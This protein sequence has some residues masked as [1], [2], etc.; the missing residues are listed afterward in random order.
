[1]EVQILSLALN[2]KPKA[3]KVSGFPRHFFYRPAWGITM[4]KRFAF[5]ALAVLVSTAV[6]LADEPTP[7][8]PP[9]IV[10]VLADDLGWRD[11]GCYGSTFYETPNLDQ[12]AAEGMR[13]TDAYAT[14]CVCSPTRASIMSGKYPAR[15]HLTDF[16]GGTRRGK[17]N[18]A[19]Y[20][21]HLPIEEFTLADALKAGGYHTG[22]IGKWHLGRKPY[23]P[24]KRGFDSNVAGCEMGAPHT[25]FSPYHIPT[26]TDG[27]T[28]EYLTDR[29][30]DEAIKFL[31]ANKEKPFYLYLCHYAVHIPLQAKPLEQAKYRAKAAQLPPASGPE[32]L[33][34]GNTNTRQI[35]NRPVYAAMVES[36][37]QSVGR[38]MQ[39]LRR[40]GLEDN[41]IVVFNS[42]NGGL[43]SSSEHA[44][45]SNAPLRAGKGWNYE[46]G[47]R[48]PLI[49][50]WPG[51]VQAGS[52]CHT[53][54]ISTD[55][56]PTLLD[57]VGLPQ[58]P[59]QTVDGVSIIPLLKGKSLAER[60]LFW[61][62]PHYS[63]QGGGPCG[64]IR[65]G[66]YKLVEWYEDMHV[67][68]FN[69]KDD[70]GEHHD[71]S[72]SLPD[73]VAMIRND[74]HRWRKSVD[75]TMPTPNP[76]YTSE[77]VGRLG[78]LN[79]GRLPLSYVAVMRPEEDDD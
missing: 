13:F 35:Q 68:L 2:D 29:L 58:R 66:D 18:P 49:V 51:V 11:L 48:E 3:E 10:F 9:N 25:Y 24:E 75:A 19:P 64:A 1:V 77:K 43:S 57:A 21:D 46:G 50:R 38:I 39:E 14:C 55:Y 63:N 61:H 79:N 16:I 62:Y 41:T 34:E 42:D 27:P 26:L 17:L 30:T 7:R 73:K 65:L 32:F 76:D 8:R 74:L 60:A 70:I 23:W 31:N 40:L 71:L 37:D 45:T 72:R 56:Y 4:Q 12:L 22:F 6:A 5:A 54:V 33:P 53:P 28:G 69:L 67:E 52:V 59:R 44:P 20:I 15:L 78:L 47:L 36:V